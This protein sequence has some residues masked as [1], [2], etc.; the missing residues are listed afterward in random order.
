MV[1]PLRTRR[2]DLRCRRAQAER[3]GHGSAGRR[4][5]SQR[6]A[7]KDVGVCRFTSA[8]VRPVIGDT[9]LKREAHQ[10]LTSDNTHH[11]SRQTNRH[12][13]RQEKIIMNA[14]K[15]SGTASIS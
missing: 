12:T 14:K 4:A 1:T 3:V 10:I 2:Q 8:S 7:V 11:P 15:L 13:D 9:L 6:G 5:V